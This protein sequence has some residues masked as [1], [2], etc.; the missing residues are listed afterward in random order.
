MTIGADAIMTET[1]IFTTL[2]TE[3]AGYYDAHRPNYAKDAIDGIAR[4][5]VC[6]RAAG[7]ARI[8]D[9]GC[10]TGIFT[11][12]IAR[13]L[14]ANAQVTGVEPNDAMRAEAQRHLGEAPAQAAPI[15]YAAGEAE[16]TGLPDGC[17]TGITAA[18]AFHWFDPAGFRAEAK[19]LLGPDGGVAALVWNVKQPCEMERER[20]R[21]VARYRSVFDVY[22]CS[23]EE[24]MRG[25]ETFFNGRFERRVYDNPITEPWEAFLARTLSSSHAVDDDDPRA[26]EYRAVWREF[27]DRYSRSGLITTPNAT[28]VYIGTI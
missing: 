2:F 16:R 5:L 19:R 28:E 12:Q 11:R 21:I 7:G 20:E 13:A 15:R 17:A 24:R 27:F 8:V 22:D 10:G 3:K 23:W 1:N 6:G 4:D 14:G 18:Q 25:I 9:V 26:A